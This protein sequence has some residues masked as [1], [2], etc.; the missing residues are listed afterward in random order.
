ME[1][2]RIRLPG[3]VSSDLGTM[4]TRAVARAGAIR[5]VPNWRN[6]VGRLF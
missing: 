1:V 4:L 6:L 2:I 3:T 5:A